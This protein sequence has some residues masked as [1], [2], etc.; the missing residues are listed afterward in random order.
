MSSIFWNEFT[1]TMPREQLDAIHLKRIQKMIR[2]AY[3]RVPFYRKLY[4]KAGLKPGDIRTLDDFNRLVPSI[5]KKDIVEAQQVEPPW[6][7][8]IALSED[9]NLFRFQTSGSTGVPMGIPVSYYSSHHYGEQWTY[10]FWGVGIRPRDSF[11]FAFAWGTFIGFWSAYWGVRRLGATVYSGGGFTTE[12]RL[13]QILEYEPTVLVCTPTYALY[14]AEKAREMGIDLPATSI[15]YTYHAGEPGGNVPATRRAIEEAW[16]AKTYELY[17]IGEVGA[18]APGCPRQ[19]GVHLAEDQAYATVVNPETG[20]PVAP[21]EVGEN[22]VTSHIQFS[23]PLIKYR[24]HDLVRPVYDKCSCGRT[25]LLFKDGVL[26]RT[27][28]MIIIKGT[29]VYPTAI[30]TLLG[31]VSGLTANY[32]IHV[33]SGQLNDEITAKVEAAPDVSASDY[34]T[35]QRKAEGIL[36]DKILVRIGVEIQKPGALPRYELKAKRFFDHREKH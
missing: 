21:G 36:Y 29:N 6:G 3:D 27:D 8:A 31:D 33:S 15:K 28:H 13:K 4:Q 30:E 19:L 17:G 26:G 10:G 23:Q 18:I 5:D 34:A 14:M 12:M 16:G 20:A 2:Y 25:W 32:E 24:S 1:E 11:Y 22:L 7:E 35:L 9:F